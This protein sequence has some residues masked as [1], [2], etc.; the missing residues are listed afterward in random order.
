MRRLDG[1]AARGKRVPNRDL[2]REFVVS[3]SAIAEFIECTQVPLLGD[4]PAGCNIFRI[5]MLR[6][7]DGLVVM[8]AS[9]VCHLSPVGGGADSFKPHARQPPVFTEP[10]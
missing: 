3:G 9:P 4:K 5:Q 6:S 2:E 8:P 7:A 1:R 10:Q